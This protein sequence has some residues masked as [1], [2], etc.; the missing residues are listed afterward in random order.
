MYH[1]YNQRVRSRCYVCGMTGVVSD[2]KG[3][4]GALVGVVADWPLYEKYVCADYHACCYRLRGRL[5]RDTLATVEDV[6]SE[7]S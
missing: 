5:T 3:E 2:I 7:V 1:D 6:K 4:P